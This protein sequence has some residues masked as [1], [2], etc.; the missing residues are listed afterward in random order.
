M[1][2]DFREGGIRRTDG[3]AAGGFEGV[4]GGDAVEPALVGEF[5]VIGEIEADEEA[6]AVV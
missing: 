1:I 3:F 6:D 4:F 5:F 2:G